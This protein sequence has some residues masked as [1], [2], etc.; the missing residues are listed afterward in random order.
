MSAIKEGVKGSTP[1]VSAPPSTSLLKQIIT[2]LLHL[3][4][5]LR[6]HTNP[7]W[8]QELYLQESTTVSHFGHQGQRCQCVSRNL[9]S[10]FAHPIVIDEEL[11]KEVR[12]QRI[13]GPF[14][15]P[16]LPNLQC[17]GVGVVPKKTGGW[18]MIMHLSALAESSINHGIDKDF[19]TSI[20]VQ[21]M[22]LFR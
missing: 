10:A 17:S 15:T 12:A 16:P 9:V 20:T 11:S 2:P 7:I 21:L 3:Q 14:D 6:N 18:R 8:V 19:F 22:M 5:E 4:E 13:A 1:L